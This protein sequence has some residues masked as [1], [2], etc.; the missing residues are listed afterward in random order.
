MAEYTPFLRRAP[1]RDSLPDALATKQQP[2]R[3]DPR[4]YASLCRFLTYP[5]WRFLHQ[6]KAWLQCNLLNPGKRRSR[7]RSRIHILLVRLVKATIISSFF[8]A[9]I[10]ILEGIIY[11]SYQHPPKHYETLRDKITSFSHS[12]R[13]N[14]HNEKI[15]IAAN[16]VNER[17]I[18]G[19]WGDALL[20]LVGILGEENVFVSI[21]EN[22]SGPGT[23]AV[24]NELR[25]RLPCNSSIVT[26]ARLPL[27]QFPAVTLPNGE[28][29]IKRIAYL[30]EVRNRALRPLDPSYTPK[31]DATEFR[32]APIKFRRVLFLNDVYFTPLDVA[33]LLFSTN[34][35]PNRRASYRAACAIDFGSPGKIYDTFVMRDVEGYRIGTPFFPWFPTQGE[36]TSRRDV[37][38]EKDAVRVRSCWGGVAAFDA[39]V[40]Q[41]LTNKDTYELSIQFRYDPEPFWEAAECCLVFADMEQR[42]GVPEAKNGTGVFVNPYVRVAYSQATWKWIQFFR[43]Y[44]RVW[45]NFQY[46][47]STVAYSKDNPRRSHKPGQ[48]VKQKIWV[49]DIQKPRRGVFKVVERRAPAGGFCGERRMFV[50]QKDIEG[51]NKSG[52]GKNWDEVWPNF[53]RER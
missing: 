32:H 27:S 20:E 16:I 37:L 45:R 43:R 53:R 49:S 39:S 51:A 1:T 12:G 2:S 34:A 47:A 29:R 22:D 9:F 28:R 46:I 10:S 5:I 13:G 41:R 17:L 38:A 4:N 52:R 3:R 18:R 15:F 40:F 6:G 7:G 31:D 19:S 24:L 33:Q 48:W 8:F 36:A 23:S 25:A 44:E 42:L 14:E 21:F 35:A 11:P 50:M 26:G 30:A